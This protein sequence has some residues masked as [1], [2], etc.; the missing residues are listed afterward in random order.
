MAAECGIDEVAVAL[1]LTQLARNWAWTPLSGYAVGA[2]A[3]GGTGRGYLGANIE[4]ADLPLHEAVHAEQAA[5]AHAAACGETEI[6]VVA[7]SEVPCGHCRQFMLDFPGTQPIVVAPSLP[8]TDLATLL[9]YGFG[10]A[11]MGRSPGFLRSGPHDLVLTAEAVA[12]ELVDLALDAA[13]HCSAAYTGSP[14]G[15]AV[16]TAD[17]KSCAGGAFES[18]AYNPT[19]GPLHAAMAGLHLG[20]GDLT[21]ITHAVLVECEGAP[22]SYRHS[23]QQL[24][25]AVQPDAVLEHVVAAPREART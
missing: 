15:A 23:A 13:R 20:G 16:F 2:V 6:R 21:M 4:F 24:L 9:P 25:G 10:P 1:A 22:I 14:A 7:S 8:P 11:E 19:I 17:G 3:V 5:I 12:G 18:V